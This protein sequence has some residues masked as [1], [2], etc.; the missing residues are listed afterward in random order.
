MYLKEKARS[1]PTSPGVYLMKDSHNGI[2]YVGKSKNLKQRVQSYFQHSKT[3][4]R[5]VER[6]VK[7]IKDFDFILTDT[8]F[9]AF[10]L[11]CQL[12]KEIKPFY[13]KLMK[14]P[15]SYTYIVIQMNEKY[16]KI[17]ITNDPIKKDDHLYFGPFTSKSTVDKAIQGLKECFKINCSSPSKK[18]TPCLNYTLGLC[19]GM[20]LGGS[21]VEQYNR[22]IDQIIDL[23]NGSDMSLLEKMQERML[24]ASEKF[25]FETATKYRDCIHAT[26]ALLN[27]EKVIAFTEANKNIVTLEYLNK[28]SFKLFLIKGK[29]VL[30]R[31]KYFLEN[32]GVE[33][34]NQTIKETILTYFKTKAPHPAKGLNRDEVD[35]AQIIYSYLKSNNCCYR[36]LPENLADIDEEINKLISNN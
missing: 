7:N 9:E 4:S 18:N 31:K 5:K 26:H 17:E 28:G 21:A 10:M 23:F 22:I 35:E 36:I 16:R 30:Y 24:Q 25:D 11:E 34:L 27:K 6:L 13:N 15:L 14:N 32:Q 12:I 33:Q 1:L 8:E 29:K 19:I 3:H 2:I 20:C